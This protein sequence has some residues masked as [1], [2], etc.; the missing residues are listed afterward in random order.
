MSVGLAVTSLHIHHPSHGAS[1]GGQHHQPEGEG[2][3]VLLH[4]LAQQG[5][6]LLTRCQ[7]PRAEPNPEES[8]LLREQSC[9]VASAKKHR[10]SGRVAAGSS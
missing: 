8:C 9:L 1:E 10:A 3:R 7:R 5:C 4:T 6:P 2:G